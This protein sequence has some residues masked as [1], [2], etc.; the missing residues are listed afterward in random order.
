[1][2]HL[3][4]SLVEPGSIAAPVCVLVVDDRRAVREGVARLIACASMALRCVGTACNGA[5]ALGATAR[6]R[7]DVVV[8]DADLDGEDGLALIPQLALTAA[9]LVL[10]CHGDAATRAR[11]TLLGARAFIEKHQPAAELLGAIAHLGHPQLGGN[12]APSAGR[13]PPDRGG[14]IL[15][16]A[17]SSPCLKSNPCTTPLLHPRRNGA[18]GSKAPQRRFS[19]FFTGASSR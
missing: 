17:R 13:K 8:L 2:P 1:M 6:L 5:E 16:C 11:A 15:R 10:S 12:E 19:H 7:P 4:S 14:N 3:L 9:V 18:M